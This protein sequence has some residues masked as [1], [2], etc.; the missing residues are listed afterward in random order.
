MK[1][2]SD[3]ILTDTGA[4]GPVYPAIYPEL[5]KDFELWNPNSWKRGPGWQAASP[6]ASR[7][8]PEKH[9]TACHLLP[10]ARAGCG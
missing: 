8:H 6:P 1:L 2:I 4:A 10:Q 3:D 9:G 7:C 5:E